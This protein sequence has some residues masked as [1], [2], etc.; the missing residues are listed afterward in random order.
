[1]EL[2]TFT[3][4]CDRPT[5][6]ERLAATGAHGL[7]CVQ[8]DLADAG[9]TSLPDTVDRAACDA[10]RASASGH[11][12][13]V[14]SLSGTY[15]MIHPDPTV[16]ATGRQR[17]GTVIAIAEAIGCGLVTLCTGTRETASM[18]RAHPE[19]ATPAAWHDL[20][21]EIAAVLPW[22]EARRITLGVEPEPGN[23]MTTSRHARRLLDHLQSPWLKVVLDP[24]NLLE[25]GSPEQARRAAD[26][27]VDLLVADVA[28]AHAKDRAADGT[29]VP[30]GTGI[31]DFPRLIGQL[32]AAGFNGAVIL[33]GLDEAALPAAVAHL[34]AAGVD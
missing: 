27:A 4:T 32:R 16:R 17:L 8:L 10:I 15:N 7:T 18:W 26:E 25:H 5:L 2:G 13:R 29:V 20:L 23:V 22:A 3:R 33:H 31:V 14:A 24:A 1:M 30:A 21:A 9:L 11:G 28:L 34:R 19:N 6:P 12:I